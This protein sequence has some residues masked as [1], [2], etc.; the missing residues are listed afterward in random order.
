M[1]HKSTLIF[2]LT[3]LLQ[4]NIYCQ[5]KVLSFKAQRLVYYVDESGSP[6]YHLP[7]IEN[8]L[9]DLSYVGRDLKKV[10]SEVINLNLLFENRRIEGRIVDEFIFADRNRTILE[11]SKAR[12]KRDKQ[13]T[14]SLLNYDKFLVVKVNSFNAL[15]EYQFLMYDVIK[16]S[17]KNDTPIL[18]NY[19]ST[20]IFIDPGSGNQKSDLAFAIKQL[21]P[22]VNEPPKAHIKVNDVIAEDSVFLAF[23]D[24][25]KLSASVIDSDSPTERLTYLWSISNDKLNDQILYGR[26]NQNLVIDSPSVFTASLLVEDG[27]N[28]S[29]KYNVTISLIAPPEIAD[30]SGGNFY[31]LPREEE[32]WDNSI[33]NI[34]DGYKPCEDIKFDYLFRKNIFGKSQ[35]IFGEDSLLIYYSKGNLRLGYK[36]V[37]DSILYTTIT[38]NEI[39]KDTFLLDSISNLPLEFK[40]AGK[41][42]HVKFYPRKLSAS[43][44]Q[45]IFYSSFKSVKSKELKVNVDF[46]KVRQISV[47]NEYSFSWL[48]PNKGSLG[49]MFLGV[50]WQPLSFAR[51]TL[52][53]AYPFY[54]A[55]KVKDKTNTDYIGSNK[56]NARVMLE[57]FKSK[58]NEMYSYSLQMHHFPV[59]TSEGILKYENLFGIGLRT[60]LP[61]LMFG[62]R[63]SPVFS[64]NYFPNIAKQNYISGFGMGEI[65]FGLRYVF[66]KRGR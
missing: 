66:L 46:I 4:I 17:R 47:L 21:C 53:G 18:S 3:W 27:I 24:T 11:N 63:V 48:G 9:K 59:V 23:N 20:S 6:A 13:I 49:L 64:Y 51:L 25:V 34:E 22:E 14:Y 57:F 61:L 8:Y 35:L 62:S 37:N 16:D 43:H 42:V 28:Q 44:Y 26:E 31:S 2:C 58:G 60:S 50:G 33:Q 30:Y 52:S 56:L 65:L 5:N 1:S 10:Y 15:L 38:S 32:I 45:F 29:K 39:L 55:S 40:K 54:S 36:N 12:D 19:R 41:Y 7:F